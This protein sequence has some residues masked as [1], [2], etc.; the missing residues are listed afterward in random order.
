MIGFK[1]YLNRKRLC[2]ASVGNDGVL[3][4]IVDCISR[5]TEARSQLTVGGLISAKNEHVK[6]VGRDL[7]I[8]D[9]VKVKVVNVGNVDRPAKRY[10]PDPTKE[11]EYQKRYLREMATKLGWKI[12]IPKR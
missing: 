6:W 1:V 4:T 7:R 2:V 3:T 11:R 12:Q 10:R 5:S 8:G 9:E